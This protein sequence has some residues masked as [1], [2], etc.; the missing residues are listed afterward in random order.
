MCLKGKKRNTYR[1]RIKNIIKM[2]QYKNI[3]LLTLIR[4]S[5]ILHDE[6]LCT[7]HEMEELLFEIIIRI[8]LFPVDIQFMYIFRIA[9]LY[10]Q[11]CRS[12]KMLDSIDEFILS[13]HFMFRMPIIIF[14]CVVRVWYP[15]IT[16][17]IIF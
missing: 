11:N 15:Y 16:C 2:K 3:P 13:V 7:S 6:F 12:K 17:K 1:F 8:N 5:I 14:L 9:Y 10:C 4:T